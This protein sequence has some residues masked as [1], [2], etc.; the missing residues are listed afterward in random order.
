M[1]ATERKSRSWN[2]FDI[3]LVLMALLAGASIYF[4]FI[5]PVS[6]SNLIHREGVS[7]YAEVEILVPKDLDWLK[8]DLPPGT[9]SK[10]VYDEVDW[11]IM[12][13]AEEEFGDETITKVISKVKIVEHSSGILQYG[14]Y[15]LVKGNKIYLM[16]DFH[17][18][19]GRIYRFKV[20]DEKALI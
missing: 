4:T 12:G 9:E 20:L 7:K 2:V 10:N 1:K 17:Y 18:L 19:E 14:K 3:F 8:H 6:F 13:W 11:R 15:T 5:K 16:N